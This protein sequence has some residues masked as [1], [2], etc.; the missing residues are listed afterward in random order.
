[1]FPACSQQPMDCEGLR[2]EFSE[3]ESSCGIGCTRLVSCDASKFY[4]ADSIVHT[5]QDGAV[6]SSEECL[7]CE[8]SLNFI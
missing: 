6:W 4:K 2:Y 1:M 8:Q 3:P 5:C 7:L